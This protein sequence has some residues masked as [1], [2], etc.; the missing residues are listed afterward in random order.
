MYFL[1]KNIPLLCFFVITIVISLTMAVLDLQRYFQYLGA[2][3]ETDRNVEKIG[4]IVRKKPAPLKE[5]VDKIKADIKIMQQKKVE[6]QRMFGKIYR[7]E[8]QQFAAAI[9]TTEDEILEK[10]AEYYKA[11]PAEKQGGVT[12]ETD[13][14]I[15]NNFLKLYYYPRTEDGELVDTP[16]DKV[17]LTA[18]QQSMKKKIE[19]ALKAFDE[20]IAKKHLEYDNNGFRYL[21]EA[22]GLPRTELAST[23][24]RQLTEVNERLTTQRIIPGLV[25][26]AD[27]SSRQT[28]NRNSGNKKEKTGIAYYTFDPDDLPLQRETYLACRQLQIRLDLYQRMKDSRLSRVPLFE[29]ITSLD[30]KLMEGDHFLAY[31]YKFSVDGE[32]DAIRNFLNNLNEAHNEYRIYNVRDIQ[33]E[34]VDAEDID[35]I[36]ASTDTEN[37]NYRDREGNLSEAYG[38]TVVGYDKEVRCTILLDYIMF[39]ADLLP[40]QI[41]EQAK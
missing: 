16:E 8:L 22:L 30:G 31:T 23:F 39:I 7:T 10:F 24:K 28:E 21:L 41:P 27:Y 29:E 40:R 12:G 13:H 4:Q 20:A 19:I 9:G 38:K 11:L 33:L 6:L 17:K 3:E 37:G 36:I 32:M 15:L 18:E 25:E 2:K 34:R 14:R 1:K 5:N 35:K 26:S